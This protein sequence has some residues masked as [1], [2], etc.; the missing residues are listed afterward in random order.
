MPASSH[1]VLGAEEPA[2]PPHAEKSDGIFIPSGMLLPAVAPALSGAETEPPDPKP[3]PEPGNPPACIPPDDC[4]PPEGI[5]PEPPVD[6]P[7]AD[8]P[9]VNDPPEEPPPVE[10]LL[11]GDDRAPDWPEGDVCEDE[12]LCTSKSDAHP[13]LLQ[14]CRK[15]ALIISCIYEKCDRYFN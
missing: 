10:G 13:H 11:P 4:Q 9:P 1:E 2:L 5:A 14:K 8:N 6:D 3:D 12:V 7:P 15:P